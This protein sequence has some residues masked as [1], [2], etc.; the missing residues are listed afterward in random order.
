MEDDED[1]DEGV[2]ERDEDVAEGDEDPVEGAAG[3]VLPLFAVSEVDALFP[4]DD[5]PVDGAVLPLFSALRAFFRAS[6]G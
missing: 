1:L 3:V 2:A 4:S 5:V 6:E